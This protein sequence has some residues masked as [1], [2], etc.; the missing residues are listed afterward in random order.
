LAEIFYLLAF[1]YFDYENFKVVLELNNY[2]NEFLAHLPHVFEGKNNYGSSIFFRYK[3][4]ADSPEE[5]VGLKVGE[6]KNMLVKD[7]QDAMEKK[8][9]IVTNEDNIREITTFVKHITSAGNIRYAADIGHDDTVMS[10]VN[11]SSVFTKHSYR[12]MVEDYANSIVSKDKLNYWNQI[13]KQIDYTEITD[14]QSILDVNRKRRLAEQLRNMNT[15]I[16]G[17]GINKW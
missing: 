6:N 16:L 17:N 15:K 14:Y 12:E 13:L 11:A 2:G 3:H 5:K 10:I 7:Y 1:E 4:R 9:F 8:N